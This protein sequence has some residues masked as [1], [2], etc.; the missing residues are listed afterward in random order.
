GLLVFVVVA[1]FAVMAP[2]NAN[3][4]ELARLTSAI[5]LADAA[6]QR[7]DDSHRRAD[8]D[9]RRLREGVADQTRRAPTAAALPQFLQRAATLSDDYGL[10]IAQVLP[11]PVQ[12][13]DGRIVCDIQVTARGDLLGLA[14]LLDRLRRENPYFSL[15]DYSVARGKDQAEERC[16]LTW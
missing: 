14:R 12:R 3:R 6:I 10:Q 9:I 15:L 1:W 4:A 7:S 5:S 13:L 11:Q 2:M 16:T 8:T